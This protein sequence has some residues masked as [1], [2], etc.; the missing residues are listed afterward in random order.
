MHELKGK[1]IKIVRVGFGTLNSFGKLAVYFYTAGCTKTCK[2]CHNKWLQDY[3]GVEELFFYD[4]N[5]RE[6]FLSPLK[7]YSDTGAQWVTILGGEPLMN[8]RLELSRLIRDA[9][10]LGYKVLLYT[11]YEFEEV[12]SYLKQDLDAIKTGSYDEDLKQE[13]ELLASSNQKLWVKGE[14]NTWKESYK[15]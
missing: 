8:D 11:G 7:I 4:K 10:N 6:E 1:P 9:K 5:N 15:I 13:G 14:D 3:Y 12:S 2:G